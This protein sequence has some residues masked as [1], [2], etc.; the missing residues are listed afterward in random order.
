V[1]QKNLRNTHAVDP[2]QFP[3]VCALAAGNLDL[4]QGNLVEPQDV[5]TS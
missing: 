5:M 4:R 2:R 3:K 1:T